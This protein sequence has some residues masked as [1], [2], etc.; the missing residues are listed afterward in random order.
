MPIFLAFDCTSCA[1]GGNSALD[2]YVTTFNFIGLP[3]S[4]T[5]PSVTVNPAF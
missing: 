1:I 3:L 4:K 5:F 2:A